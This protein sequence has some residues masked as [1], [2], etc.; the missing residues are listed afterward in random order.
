[1]CIKVNETVF[2]L[3]AAQKAHDEVRWE[4]FENYCK[5]LEKM[6]KGIIIG[7]IDWDALIHSFDI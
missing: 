1:M 7:E 2:L 5:L 6:L 3:T 4:D